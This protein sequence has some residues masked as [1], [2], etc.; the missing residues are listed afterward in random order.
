[1]DI[2]TQLLTIQHLDLKGNNKHTVTTVFFPVYHISEAK[3]LNKVINPY[4]AKLHNFRTNNS[5]VVL[6]YRMEQFILYYMAAVTNPPT[7]VM[8]LLFHSRITENPK[9]SH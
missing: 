6:F 2:N 3:K 7:P 9:V 4:K 5:I 8:L 1:M